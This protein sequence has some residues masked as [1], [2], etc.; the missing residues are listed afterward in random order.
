MLPF[1][2]VVA[3]SIDPADLAHLSTWAYAV[4]F[5]VAAGD[6][7]LPVLPAETLVILGGVLATRHDLSFW[8][9]LLAGSVGAAVG[10]NVSYQIGHS[11]N[12]DGR[13]PEDMSGRLGSALAWA[14]AALE[15]RGSTMLII[16]RFIPGART[17][18]T[19]GAG[20]VGYS[21]LRFMGMSLLAATIWASF[22]A[23]AGYVG[24]EVFEDQWWAGLA[25]GLAV[26]LAVTGMIE[27][28]RKATGRGVSIADKRAELH[29]RRTGNHPG[30]PST[31]SD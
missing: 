10:D 13:T 18:L 6:A 25:L 11:A 2:S 27:V 4:I 28:G 20:Y 22:A 21:R 7:V 5:G 15:T 29:E 26:A 30:R 14:E 9:V 8:L 19:F 12:R 16:G 17:A 24:G 23:V 31:A 1:A 3:I